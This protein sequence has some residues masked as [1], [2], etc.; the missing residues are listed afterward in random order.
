MEWAWANGVEEFT[1]NDL[2]REGV[3][4]YRGDK[5]LQISSASSSLRGMWQA[6]LLTRLA[7]GKGRRASLYAP[8]S[9]EEYGRKLKQLVLV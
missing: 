9:R 6:G 4:S 2:L 7:A 5:R 3:V 1:H 8:I